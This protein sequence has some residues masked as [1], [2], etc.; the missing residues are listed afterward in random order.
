MSLLNKKIG[1]L[2]VLALF[3][4]SSLMAL[5]P[6][7][8]T[9]ESEYLAHSIDGSPLLA[10]TAMNLSIPFVDNHYGSA[11]GIIDPTEYAYSYTDSVT[12]VKSYFE[13]NGT[14]LYV[15]LEAM[16][17]G[18]IGF[19]WQNY[20]SDFTSAGLNNSDVVVGY[21]P[22]QTHTDMWRV[23]RTDGVTVHYKLFLR[24]GSL[25]QESDYPDITSTEPVEGLSSLQMYKEAVYGMRIGE[26]RYFIIPAEEAYNSKD[27]DLYGFDLIYEIELTRIYR[28]G[29]ERVANPADLCDIVYSDEYGTNTF[30][31]LPDVDQSQILEAG[32]SDN[33]TYTQVE[34]T[35]FLNSTDSHDIPLLEDAGEMYPFVFMFGTTE[36]LNGLP[37][38]HTYW[39]EP[40]MVE[41]TPNAPPTLIIVS[42]VADSTMEWVTDVTLNA[43]NDFIRQASYRVDD[44]SWKSLHY[45][46]ITGYWESSLDLS[47]YD[48]GAHVFTFNATDPSNST[49]VSQINIEIYRTYLSLLGMRIEVT[50]DF[51]TTPSFGSRIEDS[52]TITNNGSAP[53]NAIDV[54]L[55]ERYEIHFLSM[56]SID[57]SGNSIQVV[58]RKNVDGMMHW[59]LHFPEPVDFQETYSFETTMYMHTL[60]YLSDRFEFEYQ[61]SFLKYPVLPYV[62]T[63][64]K[65]A[66]TFEPDGELIPNEVSPDA[67]TVNL[68]PFDETEF[69][70]GLRLYTENILVTRSTIAV[71]DAWG[72]ISY[73]ETFSLENTGGSGVAS[74]IFQVPAYAKNI[75]VFDEV[76]ILALSQATTAG[77]YNETN[78]V[79][80]H[81]ASDRFGDMGFA[82]NFKYTFK[83]TFVV[84]ASA[85]QTAAAGGNEISIP[86]G[87]LGDNLILTHTLKVVFPVS[88]SVSN[89]TE[90][91]RVLYGIFDTSYQYV[92]YNQTQH[93][94][95]SVTVVYQATIGAAARP[96]IFI[97]I[98]GI[99]AAIYVSYRKVELPEEIVGR[100]VDDDIDSSQSRQVGAPPELLNDFAN[101]YS[102][103]TALNMDLEKLEASRRRG[104]VKKREYMIR[105]R[106][107]KKQIEEIN[108]KLPKV[109]EEMTR[110]G[111]RYRDLVA[112]LEL[113]D[114]KIEGAKAGLRQLLLR[115]KKQRISR[116][117]FEK[118]RQDYLKTIQK[119]TTA[120]D[121]ILLT[122]QEEAG[123]I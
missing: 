52:Y 7:S 91:Y 59:K 101:L 99:I 27:H 111:P 112:Q 9:M 72:W 43:T 120:T 102:R 88:V 54:Y 123:D 96:I 83:M 15:G 115:K 26:I 75:K 70:S 14:L 68:A 65:F 64:A 25:I 23:Q 41:I 105:E 31:H 56:G 33:G 8:D 6:L 53:I 79:S 18:W 34:Y 40:A 116:V 69:Q 21:A 63:S 106:D 24:N 36:E 55:P 4:S 12:G 84:Q 48:E 10:E 74:I 49:A 28:S 117:A 16:T 66:L 58:R 30:Q 114:E 67:Q 60:F 2:M 32:G 122:I 87:L 37:V 50:R 47:S 76:G 108:T 57:E 1:T 62:L 110:H 119:A 92:F 78:D 39:T 13:H 5:T 85:Y 97:L 35:I 104:K 94:P 77:A 89:A 113:Q 17:P 38:Q 73:E 107:L 51:I 98:V 46:F 80:I 29:I 19:A 95:A 20:S 121:R 86:I 109:K 90:D 71:I 22:D 118:S 93:N 103:K 82:P 81:L 11:D 45:N 3:M 44:E 61:L 100:R 42:P